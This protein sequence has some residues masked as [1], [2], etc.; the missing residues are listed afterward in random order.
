MNILRDAASAVVK[1]FAAD[2]WLTA[3]ILS[4]VALAALLARS[5]AV[6]PLV[7]GAILLLG[8]LLLLVTSVLLAARRERG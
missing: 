3:G 8:T 5:G 2:A 4:V 7:V 6:P 1:M